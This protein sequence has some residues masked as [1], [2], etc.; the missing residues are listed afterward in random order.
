MVFC[1]FIPYINHD[2]MTSPA[3]GMNTSRI[4]FNS[5]S[6]DLV[7]S[8]VL[9]DYHKIFIALRFNSTEESRVAGSNV[10]KEFLFEFGNF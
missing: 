5:A 4:P 10:I 2:F 7:N 8:P 9:V 1:F 3:S 6:S